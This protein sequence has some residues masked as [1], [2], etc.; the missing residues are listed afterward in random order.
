MKRKK[1]GEV[2]HERGKISTEAL[3]NVIAEQRG[4]VIRLH[5]M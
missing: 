2:L 4:K 1:L 5:R 3:V